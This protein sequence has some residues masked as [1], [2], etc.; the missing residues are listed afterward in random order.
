MSH[1]STLEPRRKMSAPTTALLSTI[2]ASLDEHETSY[3]LH[4]DDALAFRIGWEHATHD[5]FMAANDETGIVSC[6]VPF[7]PRVPDARRVAVAEAVARINPR[8][9]VGHFELDFD[10]GEIRYRSTVDVEGGL[11]VT[12]MVDNMVQAAIWACERY[13]A[14]LMAVA[15]GGHEPVVAVAAVEQG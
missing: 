8:L 1:D 4:G 3:Q 5:F 10:D 11:F 7:G 2:I 6:L 15:F 9:G 13:V 14:P 12:T